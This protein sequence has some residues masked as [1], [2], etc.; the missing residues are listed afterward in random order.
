[1]IKIAI[2][3]IGLLMILKKLYII[4]KRRIENYNDNSNKDFFNVQLANNNHQRKVG[5][6]YVK[7]MR[8]DSGMLFEYPNEII[9]KLNLFENTISPPEM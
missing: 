8:L 1:M 9:V 2:V 5:L 4:I 6:M 3:V 7:K